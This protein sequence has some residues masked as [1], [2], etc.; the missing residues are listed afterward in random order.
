MQ[1]LFSTLLIVAG[2]V[3]LLQAQ[4]PSEVQFTNCTEYVGA[5]AIPLARVTPF[6]PS[7]FQ[8]LVGAGNTATLVVRAAQCEGVKVD[9]D[10]PEPGI[11]TQIGVSVVGPDGTGDINNYTV[12]YVTNSRRLAQRLE[13]V[14]LPVSVDPDLVYE[15]TP[16]PP[17]AAGEFFVDSSPSDAPAFFL[18]GTA[19]DNTFLTI[20]FLANWWYESHRGRMKM[21]TNIPTIAF[22]FAAVTAYARQ[23]SPLGKLMGGNK[24][25]AFNVFNVRGRFSTARMLVTLN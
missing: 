8:V 21:A 9:N 5:G 25:S 16:N 22:G 10:R 24:F 13:R 6:V 23:D 4:P 7:T 14:G 12:A 2:G 20:P 19:T 11:L 18:N 15:I 17:G 3:A 1:K